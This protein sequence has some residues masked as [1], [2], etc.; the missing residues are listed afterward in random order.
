[1][2]CYKGRVTAVCQDI[3]WEKLAPNEKYSD[4]FTEAI[5]ELWNNAK[6]HLPFDTCTMDILM[7]RGT[8]KDAEWKAQII[9]FNGFGAHLNTGSDLFHWVHDK[10]VLYG[11]NNGITVR[12]IEEREDDSSDQSEGHRHSFSVTT[13]QTSSESDMETSSLAPTENP[14]EEAK[15]DWLALEEKLRAKFGKLDIKRADQRLAP[16]ERIKIPLRGR[17]SSAY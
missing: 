8:A 7:T 2:F 5:V 3:W 16:S 11:E 10:D 17:W 14:T 12:F 13:A 9:E 1:M 4:G 6:S 15:P